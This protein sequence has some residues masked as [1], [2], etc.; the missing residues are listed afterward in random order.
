[1]LLPKAF[2]GNKGIVKLTNISRDKEVWGYNAS[3]NGQVFESVLIPQHIE[4]DRKKP[5]LP[6]G[7][8]FSYKVKA[9]PGRSMHSLYRAE[10]CPVLKRKIIQA[11]M[12]AVVSKDLDSPWMHCPSLNLLY[13]PTDPA[14]GGSADVSCSIR[15]MLRLSHHCH[16]HRQSP[17]LHLAR[18][19]NFPLRVPPSPTQR[20][21]PSTWAPSQCT[22]GACNQAWTHQ[23]T[24]S[25]WPQRLV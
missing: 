24:A 15:G 19:T 11:K 9:R 21:D 18:A 8:C 4:D 3:A 2:A 13:Y 17:L 10:L 14:S 1:M 23:D 12:Q 16:Y 22:V 7:W 20:L 25:L 6:S 5:K